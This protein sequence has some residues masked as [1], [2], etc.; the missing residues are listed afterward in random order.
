MDALCPLTC[1]LGTFWQS[2]LVQITVPYLLHAFPI[3][4]GI[5]RSLDGPIIIHT[6]ENEPMNFACSEQFWITLEGC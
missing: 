4:L 6:D 1:Q 3:W 5:S 2:G